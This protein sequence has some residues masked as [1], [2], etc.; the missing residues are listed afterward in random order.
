MNDIEGV[1]CPKPSGAFYAI[2]ELPVDDAENF[3]QWMLENSVMRV[4]L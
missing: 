3:C 2:A 1:V 4:I